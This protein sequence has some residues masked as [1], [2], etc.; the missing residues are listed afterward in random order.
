MS[1]LHRTK[2]RIRSVDSTR[3]ITKAM[4]LVASVKLKKQQHILENIRNYSET[5]QEIVSTCFD[6]IQEEETSLPVAFSYFPK[7]EKKLLIVVTS[8]LGLC[9]GYNY[10]IFKFMDT[11]YKEG[12][13]LLL[14][15]TKAE[16]KYQENYDVNLDERD[17][18]D[19]IDFAK[20][21]KLAHQIEKEYE[22]GIYTSC[23][24][25]YTEY[26]NSITFEPTT[27]PIFPLAM[28]KKEELGY[29][30][31]YEPNRKVFLENVVPKYIETMLYGKL[32]E[33]LV[34]EQA[35]RRNAMDNA[36]DNADELVEKLT[37]QYNK[38]RQA[39]I[40]NELIDVVAGAR[41]SA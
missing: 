31:I 37:L 28:N 10:N 32:V 8:S 26:K 15:G 16:M 2:E 1:Q 24:L 40:T 4:E 27:F 14:I 38:A 29:A 3:K 25:V 41:V 19:R 6:G 34:S 9:G 7:A 18:L 20:V 12:D 39:S 35:S 23:V 36:T 22:K 30:P 33:A 21:K 5:L 11:L 17:I 13:K